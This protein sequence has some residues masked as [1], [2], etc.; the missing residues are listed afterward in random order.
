M[1]KFIKTMSILVSIVM[2]TTS[3]PTK[4]LA[5]TNSN[6]EESKAPYEIPSASKKK[7]KIISEIKEKRGEYTKTFLLDDMTYE[8]VIYQQPVHYLVNGKWEDI[9]N[10]MTEQD[11][12]SDNE[13]V[14]EANVYSVINSDA[15]FSQDTAENN[16]SGSN[17]Q[18]QVKDKITDS[19]TQ[20]SVSN[21]KDNENA[22]FKDENSSSASSENSPKTT[23]KSK[24]F[25][26]KKNDFNV[27]ISKN[28]STK[29]LVTIKK[30]QL[31]IRLEHTKYQQ[32]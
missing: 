4:I 9:D 29:K 23:N 31:S 3:L 17:T 18:T 26:N 19:K 24:V 6:F 11:G 1:K 22:K 5:E 25:T 32:D 2:L 12:T 10:S 27:N 28:S 20:A 15:N 8:S 30:R 13:E 14:E 7:A 16:I 21:S